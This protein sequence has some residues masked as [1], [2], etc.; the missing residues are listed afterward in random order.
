M[1]KVISQVWT[2]VS[3]DDP[4]PKKVEEKEKKKKE[5]GC[6]LRA[7]F[8]PAAYGFQHTSTV[9]RSTN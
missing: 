1:K 9:H 4:L 6:I 3:C 8:E 2:K 5:K 7:G